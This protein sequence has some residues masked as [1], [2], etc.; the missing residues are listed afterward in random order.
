LFKL[1]VGAG[2]KSNDSESSCS[3]LLADGCLK[4]NY[5]D[6]FLCSSTLRGSSL[7]AN[8]LSCEELADLS[9]LGT[10]SLE[11]GVSEP[12]F[13]FSTKILTRL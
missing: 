10:F 5:D 6:S 9:S 13:S 2:L 4:S 8:I 7:S 12:L 11:V 1:K 3:T